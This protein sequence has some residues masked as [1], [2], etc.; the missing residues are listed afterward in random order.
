MI[1]ANNSK[2]IIFSGTLSVPAS[3]KRVVFVLLPGQREQ[4]DLKEW[5]DYVLLHVYCN[6]AQ[7]F[8]R[9]VERT[10]YAGFVEQ[11]ETPKVSISFEPDTNNTYTQPTS[12]MLK[13]IADELAEF[14]K[15]KNEIPAYD[16]CMQQKDW[17][18]FFS[19]FVC[20][21]GFDEKYIFTGIMRRQQFINGFNTIME[22]DEYIK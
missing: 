22:P 20:Y 12:G 2:K 17:K 4:H 16:E 6:N 13:I 5:P 15:R 7:V 14:H 3:D 9:Y 10:V 18:V 21:C 8:S 1:I 19:M 11:R